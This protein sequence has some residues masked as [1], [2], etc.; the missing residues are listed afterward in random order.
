MIKEVL[1]LIQD[2]RNSHLKE[3][4]DYNVTLD[5]SPC[6]T[7][8]VNLECLIVPKCN[9]HLGVYSDYNMSSHSK[10]IM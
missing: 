10:L 9:Y 3:I 1:R 7:A 6:G 2:F 5:K 8:V 4:K